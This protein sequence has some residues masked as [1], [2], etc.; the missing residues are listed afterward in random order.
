MALQGSVSRA[1]KDHEAFNCDFESECGWTWNTSL[2]YGF[3]R[4][5]GQEGQTL[6]DSDGVSAPVVD[7]SNN[8]QG[9]AT[10]LV[11][12]RCLSGRVS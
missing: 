6:L 10:R 2:P 1:Q 4:I 8:S 3:R 5:A 12:I 11:A 7:A 9:E